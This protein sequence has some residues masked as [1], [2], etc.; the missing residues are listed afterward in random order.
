MQKFDAH[1]LRMIAEAAP[2]G[3]RLA[4][5]KGESRIAVSMKPLAQQ[6]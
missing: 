3:E 2:C 6:E 4:S 5:G 1:T